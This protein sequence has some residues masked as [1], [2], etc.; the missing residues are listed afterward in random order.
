MTSST[1]TDTS[2]AGKTPGTGD[3]GV[4]FER[5]GA[6]V[7]I[8]FDRQ[9][10]L[11]ALD[12]GIKAALAKEIPRIA[13]DPQVYAAIF[14]AAPGRM[15][16]AGGDIREFYDLARRDAALAA[17]E[18]A[19]EYGLIWLVDCFSKPSVALIDGAVMGTG[20][21]IVQALT[22]RVAGAGYRWQMP[23]TA[24]GFFPDNGIGWHLARMPHEIGIWLGLTGTAI[25]RDDARWL[26]LATH[27][28]DARHFDAIAAGLAEAEPIDPLLDSLDEP[29]GEPPSKAL[30]PV[31]E[32][33]FSAPTVAGI[34][35]RLAAEPT[36]RA[37]CD[38]TAATLAGR[39]PTALE[40]TLQHI[41]R[42]RHLD[43][44]QTLALDYRLA[45]RLVSAHDFMEGV[46][47][48][49]VDKTGDPR[50]RPASLTDLGAAGI[51][52][53]LAPMP[54]AELELP[55]RQEM[56]ASRV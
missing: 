15:F 46:R 10:K 43:L 39:S 55:T 6:A 21:G 29:V 51:E 22:H 11:N 37:W 7:E 20:A 28:I 34:L 53:L 16:S 52:R 8:T 17:A 40:A 2:V 45:V 44:R 13:R 54:G 19:R 4:R 41:R 30:A 32:R 49:I 36:E 27:A 48:R 35:A 33:C 23:E 31:I 12:S 1:P 24:I 38:A 42:A 14:R 5:R 26:G 3:P 9:A 47:A 25:G 18:C 50:W 56:Q